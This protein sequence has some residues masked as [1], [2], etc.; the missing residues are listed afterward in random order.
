MI[1]KVAITCAVLLFASSAFGYNYSL[2]NFG[3]G[4][5]DGNNNYSPINYPVVGN[6]PSP[7]W[8]GET[9]EMFD[10]EGINVAED[11]QYIYVSIA[12][13]F[14]YNA[15]SSQFNQNYRLGDLFIGVN[16]SNNYQ[17]AIDIV[18]GG[19]NGL[20]SVSSWNPIQNVPGSYYGTSVQNQIGEFEMGSGTYL[21]GVTS[22]MNLA[23]AG[24]ETNAMNGNNTTYV[25]EFMFQ[26][27]LL[28]DYESLDFHIAVGCGNDLM[29]TT[30]DAI[31]EPTTLLLMGL[32]LVGARFVR[33]K[34]A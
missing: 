29:E 8:Y 14:G 26:K 3:S 32:G 28:G 16:G 13:S 34:K 33:R 5:L 4:P 10:L 27:S 7:G 12:N 18:N 17:Y 2:Y 6:L 30:H 19:T 25:W 22:V 21:G 24:T 11:N 15:Y 20:Y 31:P 1:K 23:P 9:G